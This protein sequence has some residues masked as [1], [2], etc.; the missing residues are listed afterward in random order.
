MNLDIA[1]GFTAVAPVVASNPAGSLTGRAYPDSLVRPDKTGFQ[2]RLGIAWR[3]IPARRWSIRAGYG[4]YR[5]TSVYQ[6]IATLLAQQSPLSKSLERA[7]QRRRI[8]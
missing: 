1:P 4:I 8:R 7:E 6:S 2:P 5:N 3:P